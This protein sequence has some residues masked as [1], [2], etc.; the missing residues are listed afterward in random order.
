VDGFNVRLSFDCMVGGRAISNAQIIG[1][2][3]RYALALA[4]ALLSTLAASAQEVYRIK[5]RGSLISPTGHTRIKETDLV[6]T[7]GHFLV[8][9]VDKPGGV[10]NL[11]EMFADG[12]FFRENVHSDVGTALDN[13]VSFDLHDSA[14][15]SDNVGG[16]PPFSLCRMIATGRITEKSLRLSVAGVWNEDDSIVFKGVITGKRLVP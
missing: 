1:I 12:N 6:A 14:G 3:N 5:I 16:I 2:M 13:R 9:Q 7:N 10:F 4:I 8:Y 15:F 11:A